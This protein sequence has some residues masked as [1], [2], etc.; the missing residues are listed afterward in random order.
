MLFS[1]RRNA[2]RF[3]SAGYRKVAFMRPGYRVS[4]KKTNFTHHKPNYKHE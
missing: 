1:W 3:L 2:L 4:V